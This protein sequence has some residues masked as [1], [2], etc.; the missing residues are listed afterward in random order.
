[1]KGFL[2]CFKLLGPK[3]SEESN[4]YTNIY[5]V[6]TTVRKVP[7]FLEEC[8][9]K[10]HVSKGKFD[11]AFYVEVDN[12]YK[13]DIFEKLYI[14]KYGK[15]EN[16][17]NVDVSKIFYF[18]KKDVESLELRKKKLFHVTNFAEN[19]LDSKKKIWNRDFINSFKSKKVIEDNV[20]NLKFIDLYQIYVKWF[21][22]SKYFKDQKHY[23]RNPKERAEMCEFLDLCETCT[24][25]GKT[26]EYY[27]WEY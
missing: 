14:Y 1:M 20:N 21:R 18:A 2:Y 11:L 17:Y 5:K 25:L 8:N 7:E 26:N 12:I 10:R 13:L 23:E 16:I 15:E 6:D 27:E 22:N 9:K 19:V 3:G 4:P 24:L